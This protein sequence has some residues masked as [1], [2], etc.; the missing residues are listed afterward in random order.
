MTFKE[1]LQVFITSR[2]SAILER[3]S[4]I[5]SLRVELANYQSQVRE[6]EEAKQYLSEIQG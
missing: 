3:D 6:L 2:N 4:I 1:M 5:E